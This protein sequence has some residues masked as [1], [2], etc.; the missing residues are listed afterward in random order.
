[1]TVVL[2]ETVS[3]LP[4]GT[5]VVP[6][7]SSA[8]LTST[9]IP[10]LSPPF[11]L[12]GQDEVCDP[13]LPEGLLQITVMNRNR[14]QMPGM[15]IN[16]TWEGGAEQFFTGLKP[17]LGSGYA[18]FIMAPNVSYTVQL[19]M[20]S[21]IAAGLTIPPCQAVNGETYRG[22]IKLTFQQP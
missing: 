2:S 13:N 6:A 12:T 20:G 9:P 3:P 17:E 4:T 5:Q 7:A 14:R 1:V 22:G 15:Q 18:D 11:I 16:I 19:A 10:T 8:P 21:E